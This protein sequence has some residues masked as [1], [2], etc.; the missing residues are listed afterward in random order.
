[1]RAHYSAIKLDNNPISVGI[2]EIKLVVIDLKRRRKKKRKKR[3][4]TVK[5]GHSKREKF[6]Y[7]TVRLVRFPI[8]EGSVPVIGTV[9][10]DL[11]SCVFVWKFVS[12]L[13]CKDI[14]ESE[15]LQTC[16]LLS[17]TNRAVNVPCPRAKVC[18]CV[19]RR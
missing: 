2:E 6:S 18:R 15:G 19:P 3:K 11:P 1:M 7:S 5:I 4:K 9:K 10:K 17:G 16:D 14:K 12:L 8:I 13:A